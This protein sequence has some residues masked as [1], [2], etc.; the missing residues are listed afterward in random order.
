MESST[1]ESTG[2]TRIDEIIHRHNVQLGAIIPA[3]QE[4]QEVYGYVPP[5]A[6]FR[7]AE[8]TGVSAS[9]IY[10]IVTFYS[11][12]RLKPLGKN[13]IRICHGTACHLSGSEQIA[14]TLSTI[15]G[16]AEGETGQDGRFTI[17]RVACLGCCSLSP[18]VTVNDEIHGRL[19][20]ETAAST[21]RKLMS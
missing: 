19:T 2:L 12:F 9:E 14:D 1:A 5:A 10:G 6:I 11:Q 4:I 17:E 21:V 20:P 13:V 16:V 7:I 8:S 18:C 3:L 15:T